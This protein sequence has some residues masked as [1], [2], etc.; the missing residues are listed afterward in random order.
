MCRRFI[1]C[2]LG[3]GNFRHKD[4]DGNLEMLAH[5]NSF[6]FTVSRGGLLQPGDGGCSQFSDS[7]RMEA[8][9]RISGL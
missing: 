6:L 9:H 2:W 4:I 8:S 7:L 3:S 1:C 5:W